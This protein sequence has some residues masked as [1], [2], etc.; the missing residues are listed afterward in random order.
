M[1]PLSTSLNQ[2]YDLGPDDRIEHHK[3]GGNHVEISRNPF[4]LYIFSNTG[5]NIDAKSYNSKDT[6]NDA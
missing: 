2:D 1:A 3:L 5:T 6:H 4:Q